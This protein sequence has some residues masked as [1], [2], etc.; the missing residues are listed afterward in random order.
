VFVITVPETGLSIPFPNI[1]FAID[2]IY[3][4]LNEVWKPSFSYLIPWVV[5]LD[6]HV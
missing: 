2:K 1:C 5:N 3:S 4:R 6:I